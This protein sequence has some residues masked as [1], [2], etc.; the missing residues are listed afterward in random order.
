MGCVQL[1]FHVESAQSI[2]CYLFWNGCY[3]RIC[4]GQDLKLVLCAIFDTDIE[5]NREYLA[6][7]KS[8]KEMN[9]I[10]MKDVKFEQFYREVKVEQRK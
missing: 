7:A 4:D 3:I 1:S 6:D 9:E 2:R 5:L 8:D 10:T